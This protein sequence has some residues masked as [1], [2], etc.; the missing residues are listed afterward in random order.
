MRSQGFNIF[1][2]GIVIDEALL[3]AIDETPTPIREPRL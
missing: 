3:W 2:N 1:F